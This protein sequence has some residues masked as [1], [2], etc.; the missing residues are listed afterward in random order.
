MNE[1]KKKSLLVVKIC[2]LLL[3]EEM[4]NLKGTTAYKQDIKNL[5]NRL[6]EKLD[7][8]YAETYMLYDQG[9][10]LGLNYTI[11]ILE[12]FVDKVLEMKSAEDFIILGESLNN[13]KLELV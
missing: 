4:D 5:I 2:N 13:H 3:A 9:E 11:K 8:E 10:E 1:V 12:S 6:S 7:R